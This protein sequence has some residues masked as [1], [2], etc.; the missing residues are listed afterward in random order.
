LLWTSVVEAL[1]RPLVE[2]GGDFVELIVGPPAQIGTLRQVLAQQTVGVL[3][4]AALSG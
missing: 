1:T 2:F 4:A 3:V